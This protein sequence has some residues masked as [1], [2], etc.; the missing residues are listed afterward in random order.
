MMK[1]LLD[2]TEDFITTTRKDKSDD[3][4]PQPAACDAT[5]YAKIF[6]WETFPV[7]VANYLFHW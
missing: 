6:S 3:A 5:V 1:L 2:P 4:S 7:W